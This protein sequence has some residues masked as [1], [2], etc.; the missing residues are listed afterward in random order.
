[1]AELNNDIEDIELLN[2]IS[3]RRLREFYLGLKDKLNKIEDII[4]GLWIIF[5][6]FLFHA[7]N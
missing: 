5:I 3:V 1:M 6:S 7:P 4:E 2:Y